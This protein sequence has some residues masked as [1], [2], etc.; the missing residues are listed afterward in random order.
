MRG[1][2]DSLP[3]LAAHHANPVDPILAEQAIEEGLENVFKQIEKYAA[4]NHG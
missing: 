2:L 4:K 1:A 3:K